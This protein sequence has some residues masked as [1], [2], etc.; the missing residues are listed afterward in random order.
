MITINITPR[1]KPPAPYTPPAVQY[2]N[3]PYN[4]TYAN[5]VAMYNEIM[6]RDKIVKELFNK[7]QYKAGD[8]IVPKNEDA[9]K[10]WGKCK[11]MGVVSEY[12]HLEK[13]YKWP[14]N[15]NPMIVTV[16]AESGEM[17]YATTNYF[18]EKVKDEA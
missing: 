17:F 3:P 11:V 9:Q 13:D 8:E 12:V 2:T 10:K 18:K 16:A 15:D 6:R 1:K 4:H 5:N 14:K 7:F